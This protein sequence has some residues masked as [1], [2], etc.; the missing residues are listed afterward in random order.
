MSDP[1]LPWLIC[2]DIRC[3]KRLSRLHRFLCQHAAPV[4]YSVFIGEY[5]RSE[6]DWL[7]QQISGIIENRVDDVRCYPI[8]REPCLSMIGTP[9]CPEGWT[10]MQQLLES[11]A[12]LPTIAHGQRPKRRGRPRQVVDIVGDSSP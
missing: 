5:R 3:P 6:I 7:C 10:L 9:R 2:Y 12:A 8:P 4:Q 1:R 11:N